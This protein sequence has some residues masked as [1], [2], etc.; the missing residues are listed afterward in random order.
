[1][2]GA[3]YQT[4]LMKLHNLRRDERAKPMICDL[5]TPPPSWREILRDLFALLRDKPQPPAA[6]KGPRP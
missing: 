1:M 4:E 3:V 6:T 2:R 5:L